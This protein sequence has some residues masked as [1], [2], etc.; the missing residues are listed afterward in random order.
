[1]ALSAVDVISGFYIF[2]ARNTLIFRILHF[3]TIL[4]NLS[5]VNLTFL[6]EMM[7]IN[8]HTDIC[9]DISEFT[10]SNGIDQIVDSD[11]FKCNVRRLII[12]N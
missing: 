10:V 8:F 6:N 9:A 2:Q 4:S 12:M 3:F 11:F 1:M 7:S 5:R